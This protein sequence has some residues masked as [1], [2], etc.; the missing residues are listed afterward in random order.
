MTGRYRLP[1][2]SSET[3]SQ[4]IWGMENQDA[5]YML[6]IKDGTLYSPEMGEEAPESLVE[7]PSWGSSDGYQLMVSFT[8]TCKDPKLKEKLSKELSSKS[9]GVFRR[10]RD[11]LSEDPEALKAWY[12]FKDSRMRS[13]IISWYREHFKKNRDELES[14]DLY[15]GELLS[16]FE[17]KHL[18]KLDSYCEKLLK[19]ASDNPIRRKVLGAFTNKEA[20]E[21]FENDVPKGAIIFEVT[22]GVACILIYSIEEEYRE[23]GLFNLL[24][25]LFNRDMER[26]HIEQVAMVFKAQSNFIKGVF[27]LHETA[28]TEGESYAVYCVHEWN[29]GTDSSE[30]AYVL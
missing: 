14:D 6:N 25:D 18:E 7:L 17:V 12:D 8:N 11:V 22:D 28:L 29:K 19:D 9:H 20:Y 24:F 5:D 30:T 2:F 1:V 27:A 21:I 10:F 4:I 3:L 23:Q 15:E 13:H 26:R 16:E